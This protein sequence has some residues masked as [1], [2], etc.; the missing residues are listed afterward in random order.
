M[1]ANRSHGVKKMS[2][3]LLQSEYVDIISELLKEPYRID[4]VLKMVFISFCVRNESRSSYRNR[5]TDFV[6][7]LLENL[8]LKLLSHPDE[9]Q[10]IFEVLN[11]LKKC[12]WINT[13]NGKI[14]ILKEPTGVKCENKFLTGCKGKDINPIVEV[15]K[16][17]DRAF[18]EEVLRHV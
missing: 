6:D 4:S 15:N 2:D 11:K 10:S 7:A 16:L 5:K 8:N 12:G 13:V 1:R 18:I 3:L 14:E 17:D 9:L